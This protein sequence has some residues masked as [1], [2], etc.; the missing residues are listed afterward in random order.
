MDPDMIFWILVAGV[1]LVVGAVVWS[2]CVL[3]SR[4]SRWRW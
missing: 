2:M 4:L 3:S 1:A